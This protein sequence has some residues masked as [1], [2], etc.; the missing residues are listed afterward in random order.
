MWNKEKDGHEFP[1]A[2][3]PMTSHAVTSDV[4]KLCRGSMSSLFTDPLF[5]LWRFSSVHMKKETAGDLLTG[6]GKKKVDVSYS[7]TCSTLIL[8]FQACTLSHARSSIFENNICI[9]TGYSWRVRPYIAESKNVALA[10]RKWKLGIWEYRAH[11]ND[12]LECPPNNSLPVCNS[13]CPKQPLLN[14]QHAGVTFFLHVARISNVESVLFGIRK[15]V[16]DNSLE[17]CLM[18]FAC[19]RDINLLSYFDLICFQLVR[20][21]FTVKEIPEE[22]HDPVYHSPDIHLLRLTK[23]DVKL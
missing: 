23:K 6:W 5:S 4:S 17:K 10:I 14:Q 7:F 20:E 13:Q 15:D 19:N 8:M 11:F 3:K 18:G 22:H 9:P 2:F 1:T 16:E 21:H 12:L